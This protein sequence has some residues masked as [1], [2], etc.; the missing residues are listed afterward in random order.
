MTNNNEWHTCFIM[1][2]KMAKW[3]MLWGWYVVDVFTMWCLMSLH[4]SYHK[5][6]NM[7]NDKS[8]FSTS[9]LTYI[10][11][12]I[13]TDTVIHIDDRNEVHCIL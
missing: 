1:I 5:L 10:K 8:V 7:T 9:T 11:M 2:S 12:T 6:G 3:F 4:A 13:K